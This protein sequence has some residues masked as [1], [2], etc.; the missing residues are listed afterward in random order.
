MVHSD[1]IA[2]CMLAYVFHHYG[3]FHNPSAV[4]HALTLLT[5]YKRRGLV[6]QVN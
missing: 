2:K 5:A 1:F 4:L 3:P 6:T